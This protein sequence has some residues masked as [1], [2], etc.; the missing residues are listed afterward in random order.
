[1]AG[2]S[3]DE[4]EEPPKSPVKYSIRS[5]TN[6]VL[7]AISNVMEDKKKSASERLEEIKKICYLA[8]V[9]QSLSP[10]VNPVPN[11]SQ[12]KKGKSQKRV[13]IKDRQLLYTPHKMKE[14]LANSQKEKEQN[15]KKQENASRG[16]SVKD[17]F[18]GESE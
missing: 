16:R 15:K 17:A 8:T 2:V 6:E 14:Y 5:R 9:L 7:P 13:A 18:G 1:A 3:L 10:G 11:K 12:K 4:N